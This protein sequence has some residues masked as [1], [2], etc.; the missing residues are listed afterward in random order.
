MALSD[1]VIFQ[2]LAPVFQDVFDD[3]SL[4]PHAEL[5]AKDVPEWDS[6][7]HIRLV[8]AVEEEFSI[9]L[10]TAELAGLQNVGQMVDLIRSKAA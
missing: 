3:D 6:I 2:R 7:S 4:V 9:T 10:T 8:V 5:S 1:E